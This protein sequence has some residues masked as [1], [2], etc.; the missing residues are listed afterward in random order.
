[1]PMTTRDTPAAMSASA[2]GGVL[3][4]WLQ[5][6][7][8]TYDVGAASGRTR[9]AQREDLG[10]RLAGTRVEA[11]AD[12]RAVSDDDAADDGI[13][14]SATATALGKRD[15]TREIRVIDPGCDV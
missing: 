13:G 9:L 15:G 8:V 11:L 5:G 2:H 14:R 10:V 12:D 6:S 4:W 3:P 1:M 7:S